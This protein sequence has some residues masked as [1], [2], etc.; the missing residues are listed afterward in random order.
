MIYKKIILKDSSKTYSL[1]QIVFYIV[2][3]PIIH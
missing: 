3:A 2:F 1:V